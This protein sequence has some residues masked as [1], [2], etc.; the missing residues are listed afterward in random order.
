MTFGLSGNFPVQDAALG[1]G[2][3]ISHLIQKK[4]SL[5]PAQ[6]K[7]VEKAIKQLEKNEEDSKRPALDLRAQYGH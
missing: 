4:E 1:G 6:K 5:P 7:K 2:L 3:D